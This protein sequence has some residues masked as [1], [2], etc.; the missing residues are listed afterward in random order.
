MNAGAGLPTTAL[1]SVGSVPVARGTYGRGLTAGVVGAWA[2][3]AG[4]VDGVATGA[5]VAAWSL[6]F[7]HAGTAATVTA[8]RRA[9][10]CMPALKHGTAGMAAGRA[11][12]YPR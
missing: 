5:G 12:R 2:G 11:T 1:A 9:R 10:S 8:R 6:A 4:S 7:L 3:A